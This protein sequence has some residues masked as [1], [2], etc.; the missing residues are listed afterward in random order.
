MGINKKQR[1]TIAGNKET[2]IDPAV[3]RDQSDPTKPNPIQEPSERCSSLGQTQAL[4]SKVGEVLFQL[5]IGYIR[6]IA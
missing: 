2:P 3:P 4:N 5:L 1:S 6:Q